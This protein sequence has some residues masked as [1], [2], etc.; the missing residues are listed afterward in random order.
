M[1]TM[2]DRAFH[3][4]RTWLGL[5]DASEAHLTPAHGWLLP[6]PAEVLTRQRVAQAVGCNTPAFG[7]VVEG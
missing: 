4:L 7:P 2:M 1:T 3:A 5:A 6:A